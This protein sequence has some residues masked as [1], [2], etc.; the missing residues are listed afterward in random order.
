MYRKV[1]K[2]HTLMLAI[3]FDDISDVS[4]DDALSLNLS[5]FMLENPLIS[6]SSLILTP[7]FLI[8]FG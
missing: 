8:L 5:I 2:K 6:F 4:A 7:I 3:F 1:W